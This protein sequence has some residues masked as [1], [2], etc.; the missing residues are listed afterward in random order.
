M[1]LIAPDS[2]WR[3][4]HDHLLDGGGLERAAVGFAGT[5]SHSQNLLLRDWTPVQDDEY[6]VQ[7]PYHLEVSPI[8]WARHAKRSR[9]TGEALVIVHSHPTGVGRPRFSPSDDAGEQALIPKIRSR[10]DGLVVSVVVGPDGQRGRV[11]N[12]R[13]Q[14]SA[15][16]VEPPHPASAPSAPGPTTRF[17]FDRQ[18]RLIGEA[19]Q[20]RLRATH[21][22]VVGAGGLGSQIAEQLLRLG[23]SRLTVL[24]PDRVERSN[25]SRMIGS[26]WWDPLLRSRK[27]AV[28]RRQARRIGGPARLVAR[29]GDVTEQGS[30]ALLLEADVIIGTTDTQ[31]SRAVLN[32]LAY[33][34]YVPVLD[35]GVELQANGAMGGRVTWLRPGLPCL[36]CRGI[37]DPERVR[38]EQLPDSVRAAEVGAGY[39]TGM[40]VPQPAVVSINGVIA[41]LAVTELLAWVTGFGSND[42][43]S[44]LVYRL[45]DGTVRRVGGEPKAACAV[46]SVDGMLGRGDLGD[47]VWSD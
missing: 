3:P 28:V 10:T 29:M 4:L 1:K 27:T 19:G 13:T 23:V 6:L 39:V 34:Y 8:F 25:V 30:G 7:L 44:M 12:G 37:L 21:V 2:V 38:V 11:L 24:D 20:R 46:C 41:S 32:Q 5:A 9:A 36:W 35:T 31:W 14:W 40:T 47:P 33:Q 42:R 18:I 22:G 16:H 26:A 17:R 43:A 45:I 15:L